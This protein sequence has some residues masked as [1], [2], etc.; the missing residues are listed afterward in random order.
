MTGS[1]NVE[2]TTVEHCEL[3]FLKC[4]DAFNTQD[5]GIF[6]TN[7]KNAKIPYALSN[8]AK[9]KQLHHHVAHN[10]ISVKSLVYYIKFKIYRMIAV[11]I[12][13]GRT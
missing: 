11:C 10:H 4:L 9:K 7:L 3:S 6:A 5:Y 1:E 2:G 8:K 12:S 13:Y